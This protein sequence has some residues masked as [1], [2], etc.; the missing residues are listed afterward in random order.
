MPVGEHQMCLALIPSLRASKEAF[1]VFAGRLRYQLR[2][3]VIAVQRA[4]GDARAPVFPNLAT[5]RGSLEPQN[6]QRQRK[7][8]VKKCV[9]QHV[10]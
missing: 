9:F 2:R 6:A 10:D 7:E 8:D 4:V 3:R 1:L 5:S